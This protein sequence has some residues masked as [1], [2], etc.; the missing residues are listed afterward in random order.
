[1]HRAEHCCLSWARRAP[2]VRYVTGACAAHAFFVCQ[3]LKHLTQSSQLF[4]RFRQLCSTFW[5]ICCAM[6]WSACRLTLLMA[7]MEGKGRICFT[8][9]CAVHA[10]LCVWQLLKQQTQSSPLCHFLAAMFYFPAHVSCCVVEYLPT[11]FAHCHS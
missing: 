6:W 11:H 3:L 4:H 1:M 9:A 2:A 8:E 7:Q 5:R 10:F